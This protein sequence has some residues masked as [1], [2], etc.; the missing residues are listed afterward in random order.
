MLRQRT[1]R[2]QTRAIGVGLHSGQRVE[3][4]LRPA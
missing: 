2:S 3:L 4:T 1:L